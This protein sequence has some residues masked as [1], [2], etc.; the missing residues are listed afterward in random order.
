MKIFTRDPMFYQNVVRIAVPVILQ[1]MITIGVNL[2]DTLMLGSYGDYQL[3]GSSLANEF[4]SIFQIMCMG[5]GYGAAVLTAQYWGNKDRESLKII[6]T[7]MLRIGLCV[8]ALFSI[9]T[10]C[11][12]KEIMRFYTPDLQIIENGVK[13]FKISAFTYIPMVLALT[14]T[15]AMRSVRQVRYPLFVSVITFFV[16]VSANWI[17]IFGN[18]G[19]PELQIEGAAIGT[20][21]ARIFEAGMIVIYFFVFDSK[22]GYRFKDLFR[23]CRNLIPAYLTYCVP[24]IISDTLLGIGNTMVSVIMGHIG[25]NFVAANAIIAQVT[26]MSTV[27]TQGVSSASAVMIGNTVGA[28]DKKKAK[29][30]GITFWG[31]GLVIGCFAGVIILLVCPPIIRQFNVSQ[32][33]KAIAYQLMWSVA[34]MVVF[35]SEQSLLT[36]GVLRGGGDTRFLMVADIV[37]LWLCAIPLGYLT[38]IVWKQSAF[39]VYAALKADWV[40]KSVLCSVRLFLHQWIRKV[41]LE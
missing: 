40:I 38:G 4:I 14:L 21:I 24:V 25:A 6:V 3:S 16:N 29:E 13:Y 5:L 12:P 9:V 8:A 11:M 20:L 30:Q 39:F 33:T 26:R 17:F 41:T 28:G 10:F 35:Q 19:A 27:F 31:L 15:A 37:F 34:I 2:M 23:K 36:K 1:S 7:I 32:E 18:F 22:I